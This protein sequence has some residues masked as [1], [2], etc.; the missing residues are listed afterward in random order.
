MSYDL[1]QPIGYSLKTMHLAATTRTCQFNNVNITLLLYFDAA[2]KRLSIEIY[3]EQPRGNSLKT[4]HLA[5][6]TRTSQ[7]NDANI[8]L[9]L[10]FN[11]ACK[12][13]LIEI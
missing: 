7:F 4:M 9:L 5:T 6:T 2:C 13:L 8:T 11:A 3:L 10:Y 1:E 12:R